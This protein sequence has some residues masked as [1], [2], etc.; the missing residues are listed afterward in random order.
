MAITAN[1]I[2]Q[3]IHG[4][5]NAVDYRSKPDPIAYAPERVTFLSYT[6]NTGACGN[7]LQV[8]GVTGRHGF[9]HVEETYIRPGEV[10]EKGQPLFKMGYNGLTVPQ[11]PEGRHAHWVILRNGVYVYPPSL[12]KESFKKEE[13]VTMDKKSLESIWFAYFGGME[14]QPSIDEWVGKTPQE[15][16]EF[17]DKHPL[18]KTRIDDLN[19][20]LEQSHSLS[21]IRRDLGIK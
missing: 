16:T 4:A 13:G 17:L 10:L 18:R 6:E 11:G 19:Y 21:R 9:C 2:S 5:F 8:L 7:N 3:T 15:V 14:N 20:W 12:I 1:E